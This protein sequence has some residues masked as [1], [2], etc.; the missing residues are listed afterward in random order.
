MPEQPEIKEI[1]GIAKA[2]STHEKPER[3]G[4]NID[5]IWYNRFGKVPTFVV[6]GASLKIKYYDK[7]YKDGSG[8]LQH[9]I[10][11]IELTTETPQQP[12]PSAPSQRPSLSSD[13]LQKRAKNI[14][15]SVALKEAVNFVSALDMADRT[16][17]KVREVY[18]DF[19]NI[20]KEGE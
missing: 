16:T 8:R 20:L 14:Q 18:K 9:A 6:K 7:P 3:Y 13:Y 15:S 4:V 12:V 11:S 5:N 19:I 2:V 17:A 10:T 1:I